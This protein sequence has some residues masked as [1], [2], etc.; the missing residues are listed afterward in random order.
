MEKERG[1]KVIT[2]VALLVAIVGLTVGFAAFTRDLNIS[3][4]ESKVNVGGTLDVKYLASD[5]PN[6]TNKEITG[7]LAYDSSKYDSAPFTASNVMISDD[8]STLS[9]MGATFTGKEQAVQYDVYFYN[10]SEYDVY[11]TDIIYEDYIGADKYKVCTALTGTDQDLVDTACENIHI[12][13]AIASFDEFIPI[14]IDDELLISLSNGVITSKEIAHFVFTIVYD[15][16]DS[17][18]LKLPEGFD[19]TSHVIP[20]GDFKINFGNIKMKVSSVQG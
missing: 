16:V 1:Y 12:V 19:G 4:S 20:N 10:N 8:Y 18:V 14:A 5:D 17:D 3:F 7:F 9:G 6:D 11:L 13:V 15:D 2:I